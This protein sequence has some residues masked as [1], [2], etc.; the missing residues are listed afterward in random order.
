[1]EFH[2]LGPMKIVAGDK[3]HSLEGNRQRTLLALLLTSP[4]QIVTKERFFE[5]LWGERLPRSPENAL[6]AVVA[7]MRKVVVAEFG[8]H[9]TRE[10]LRT[11][12]DGY[13]LDIE[14][15]QVD[16]HR[17]ER[18]VSRAKAKAPS[19]ATA[20][21]DLLDE[22]LALWKGSALQGVR[23]GLTCEG[24]AAQL[25]ENRLA[26]VEARIRLNI[27]LS[28]Y[29]SV[30]SELKRV[31]LL[32][33]WRER[34]FELLMVCLYRLG[35]QAEAVEAYNYLRNRLVEEYG[36]EPSPNVKKCMQAI[37]H[38]DPSLDGPER[39][40]GRRRPAAPPLAV[41]KPA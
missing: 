37:L 28:G 41:Q 38:Q 10:R 2:I 40:V 9:L 14:P 4:G 22:A 29:S 17:F 35:R 8:Q 16:A 3:S 30:I 25:E 31:V 24:V 26:A 1:M 11:H 20:A 32:C 34:L 18:L 36:M 5:E 39:T 33:P 15:D 7:R 12:P 13:A 6:Q 27:S 23:G 21:R 19:D